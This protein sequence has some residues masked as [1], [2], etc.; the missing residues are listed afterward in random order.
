[1]MG[2][3]W[4]G[5]SGLAAAAGLFGGGLLP[6]ASSQLPMP[7]GGFGV[8]PFLSSEV[9][10]PFAASVGLTLSKRS[11]P[12]EYGD[13]DKDGRFFALVWSKSGG[14]VGIE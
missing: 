4:T 6:G 11:E 12:I 9:M 2:K 1:M 7:S 10:E 8:Q 3:F 5:A 14:A 13:D